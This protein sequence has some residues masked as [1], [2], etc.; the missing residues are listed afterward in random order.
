MKPLRTASRFAITLAATA[1]FGSFF[2]PIWKIELW[3]PQYP[4]GLMMKIW[5]NHLSGDVEIINGLN[6]YIG[7]AHIKEEMF[8]EFTILSYLA[9]FFVILGL[10]IAWFNRRIGALAYLG[11]ILVAGVVAM[12]DFYRWGYQYG[13]N[14]DPN[15]AIKVPGM[16]YQPPLIGYKQLLNFGAYS[17]PDWGGYLFI[18]AGILVGLVVACEYYFCQK[19]RAKNQHKTKLPHA[20]LILLLLLLSACTPKPSPIQYGHDQ[21]EF[22]KMTIMD[23]RFGA[24]LVT[25]KGKVYKFDDLFC[26]DKYYRMQKAVYADYAHILV[27][28]YLQR[29]ALIDLPS[30]HLLK[31]EDLRSPMGGNIAAFASADQLERVKKE[32]QVTGEKLN[33]SDLKK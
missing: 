8:P 27:N 26:L 1:M 31:A 3:A 20:V 14:L 15:A 25:T 24:E 11:L 16:A 10:L 21:C 9:G 4:E 17:V 19:L 29:G 33:W 13:H 23:D 28:D 6:H 7:M 2:L 12:I 5:L 30:A 18:F 32:K 22:C